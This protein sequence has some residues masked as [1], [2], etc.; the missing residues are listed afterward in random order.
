MQNTKCIFSVGKGE[1]KKEPHIG[2][3]RLCN[4]PLGSIQNSVEYTVKYSIQLYET[5]HLVKSFL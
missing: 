3:V 4:V 1:R 5:F 2:N